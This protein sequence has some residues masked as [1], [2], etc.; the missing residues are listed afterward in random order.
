MYSITICHAFVQ[1]LILLVIQHTLF[2]FLLKTP[3]NLDEHSTLY[4]ITEP[5]DVL[6]DVYMFMCDLGLLAL[7]RDLGDGDLPI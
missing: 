3:R 6:F 1:I 2:L 7:L 4:V 5:F